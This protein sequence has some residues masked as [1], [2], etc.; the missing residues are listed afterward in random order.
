M[1]RT[2]RRQR[3]AGGADC[4]GGNTGDA[5][6]DTYSG[7]EDLGGTQFN[8]V[9]GGDNGANQLS[10]GNGNDDMDGLQGADSLYGGAG[11]DR[12]IGGAGGDVLDGGA[13]TYDGASYWNS[14][15]VRADLAF[16][17]T[18]TGDAVGDSYIGIENLQ[19][20]G[21]NDILG[22]DN[23]ANTLGGLAGNDNMDGRGGNDTLGGEAG[24]DTLNGG[25]GNDVLV[26]AAGADVFVFNAA[27]GAS[28][29]DTILSY[30][31]A[32]DAIWLEN[33]VMTGLSAGALAAS[34]FVSG[35]AAT[36][37]AHRVIYNSATGQ[38]LYDADGNAGAAAVLIANIGTGL[39]V[40]AGEFLVI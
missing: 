6:G 17:A 7:V 21:F 25:A 5:A 39:A 20:S 32:D 22:G 27:I 26:G 15:A 35:A 13:G 9:L 18:N 19:G 33:A 1:L 38:L 40:T 34:A 36:T 31:V 10:G 30:V 23:N 3:A 29:V 37:A 4:A 28:N 2:G 14:A 16:S 8:D 12:L 11:N 24:N